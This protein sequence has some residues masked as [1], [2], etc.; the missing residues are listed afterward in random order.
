LTELQEANDDNIFNNGITDLVLVHYHH[1]RDTDNCMSRILSL[2]SKKTQNSYM[3]LLG[4]DFSEAPVQLAFGDRSSIAAT[5]LVQMTLLSTTTTTSTNNNS[6]YPGVVYVSS[7][8]LFVVLLAF[9]LLIIL[10][11]GVCCVTAIESPNRFPTPSQALP[12]SKEY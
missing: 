8:S 3:A 2:V 11:T 7:S 12:I 5:T 4:A 9:F 1:Q 6:T 10:F